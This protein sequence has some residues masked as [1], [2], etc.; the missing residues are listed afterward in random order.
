MNRQDILVRNIKNLMKAHGIKSQTALAN[1]LG[2]SQAAINNILNKKT[3]PNLETLFLICDTFNVTVGQLFTL[4]EEQYGLP[5][6]IVESNKDEVLKHLS[7]KINEKDEIID[8]LYEEI[9]KLKR[10]VDTYELSRDNYDQKTKLVVIDGDLTLERNNVQI[11]LVGASFKVDGFIDNRYVVEASI[12][13]DDIVKTS[14][15]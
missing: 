6:D 3:L 13:V 4:D 2:V 9:S 14:K 5:I 7:E 8:D 15:I 10:D 11:E 12:L 1:K